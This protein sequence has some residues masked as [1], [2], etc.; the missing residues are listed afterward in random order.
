M[1]GSGRLKFRSTGGC[2]P[3]S[4]STRRQEDVRTEQVDILYLKVFRTG[5]WVEK[6][7]RNHFEK[8]LEKL[9]LEQF[10]RE[11]IFS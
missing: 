8:N 2:F 9:L 3:L 5:L 10:G 11:E 1:A 7:V 6:G 4:H